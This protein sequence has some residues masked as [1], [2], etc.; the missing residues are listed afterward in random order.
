MVVRVKLG[1]GGT[2][3]RKRGKNRHL[4]LAAAALLAPVSL[5]A[6]VLGVWRLA[7]DMGFA[8]AFGLTGILSHWQV[9]IVA[10]VALHASATVLNRYGR[11]GELHLPKL[12]TRFGKPR[13]ESPPRETPA[14][15]GRGV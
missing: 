15:I 6:Y 13:P 3:S 2:V 4:A 10:A 14:G 1:Q 7:S 12:I 8:G 11:E 5:M 9:W